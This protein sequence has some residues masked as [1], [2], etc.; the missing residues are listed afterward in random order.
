MD[1]LSIT[2]KDVLANNEIRILPV[3]TAEDIQQPGKKDLF[4]FPCG[5]HRSIQE[6]GKGHKYGKHRLQRPG[7][8]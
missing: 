4:H 1:F 7:D 8:H 5:S 6:T 2:E 3:D